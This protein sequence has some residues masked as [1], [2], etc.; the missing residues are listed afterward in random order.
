MGARSVRWNPRAAGV[1]FGLSFAHKDV[2]IIRALMEG[3][4]FEERTA[5][6]AFREI[7]FAPLEIGA[8][9]GGSRSEIWNQI[10]ADVSGIRVVTLNVSDSSLLEAFP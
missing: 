7:G 5:L 9:G 3:I 1:L 2:E 8:L 6:E 10:K 4:A